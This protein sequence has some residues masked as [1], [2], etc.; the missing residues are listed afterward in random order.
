MLRWLLILIAL[1]AAPAAAQLAPREN[2]IRPELVAEGPAAPGGNPR[3]VPGTPAWFSTDRSAARSMTSIAA[4]CN[5]LHTLEERCARWLLMMHDRVEGDGFEVTHELL[6]PMLGVLQGEGVVRYARGRMVVLDR[7][8]LAGAS[9]GCYGITRAA[10][11]R[12]LG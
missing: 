11:A 1:I 7:R 3:R 2:A 9:C 4:A 12:L 5:R 10:L 8:R 6:A